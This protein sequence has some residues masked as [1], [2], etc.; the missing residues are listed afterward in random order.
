ML[1]MSQR[2]TIKRT[3]GHVIITVRNTTQKLQESSACRLTEEEDAKESRWERKNT[4]HSESFE[5][6]FVEFGSTSF[7]FFF[8]I[9]WDVRTSLRVPRLISGSIE[10][11]ASP[12]GRQDTAKMTDVHAK[13]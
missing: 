5:E 13:A 7:F 12:V 6:I 3:L 1:K 9:I 8:F 2:K 4:F 10:H 11:P